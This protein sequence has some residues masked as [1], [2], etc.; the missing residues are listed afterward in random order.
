MPDAEVTIRELKVAVREFC[1]DRDWDQYHSPKDLAIAVATEAAELLEIVRFK[2][3]KE[4]R[5]LLKTEEGRRRVSDELADVLYFLLRFSQM[6]KIDLS[7]ALAAK[8]KK[9]RERYP[10]RKAKG[11]NRKYNEL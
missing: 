7:G 6:N 3:D 11:S 9:N 2:S 4:I 8:M 10:I 5:A 1:E